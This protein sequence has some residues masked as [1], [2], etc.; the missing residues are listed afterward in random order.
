[1]KIWVILHG[2][3]IDVNWHLYAAC[4]FPFYRAI[5]DQGDTEARSAMHLAS[6]YAGIGFGNAGTHLPYVALLIIYFWIINLHL[7]YRLC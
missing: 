4:M 2:L 7:L 3:V 5:Y 6:C 1:M